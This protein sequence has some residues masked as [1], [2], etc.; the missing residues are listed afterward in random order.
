MVRTPAAPLGKCAT[1]LAAL[2][3]IF[4]LSIPLLRAQDPL[5]EVENNALDQSFRRWWREYERGTLADLD[6]EFTRKRPLLHPALRPP[7][8][9]YA[10]A[11]NRHS[12]SLD[13]VGRLAR[14]ARMDDAEHVVQVLRHDWPKHRKAQ[15]LRALRGA[16]LDSLAHP[17]CPVTVQ[18]AVLD[19]IRDGERRIDGQPLTLEHEQPAFAAR[20][21]PLLAS[22]HPTRFRS[23]L[24]AYCRG[25]QPR[26]AARAAEALAR[27]NPPG[28]LAAI[29][30][31]IQRLP[32]V[33]PEAPDPALLE[34]WRT[35]VQA[36]KPVLAKR[37]VARPGSNALIDTALGRCSS[38]TWLSTTELLVPLILQFRRARSVPVLIDALAR[39]HELSR[40]S[41][42]PTRLPFQIAAVHRALQ[43]LTGFTAPANT[44]DRWREFWT[45]A[46][47][48]FVVP[49]PKPTVSTQTTAGFYGIPV[50]GRRVVFILDR[51][52][53]M[54]NP[55]AVETAG[56]RASPIQVL[57]IDHAKAELLAAVSR[58]PENARF[59][60]LV[61]GD[62]VSSAANMNSGKRALENLRARLVRIRPSGGTHLLAALRHGL[63]GRIQAFSGGAHPSVD[64]VF[65]LSDG[66][67]ASAPDEILRAV[68]RW[69]PG[70][71]ARIHA[72][73]LGGT[74]GA[75]VVDTSGDA[76]PAAFMRRLAEENGGQFRQAR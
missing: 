74:P 41:R 64:E 71:T 47:A 18:G 3:P 35:L 60:V 52:G 56:T 76:S 44:P 63:R 70:A 68:R 16:I 21:L 40:R 29:A 39:G 28:T 20:V 55:I 13:L 69:N 48:G 37:V 66:A 24:L 23:L 19:A 31:A 15:A 1:L 26:V 4:V 59:Q 53:S 43:D 9:A 34:D 65:V 51:S 10:G 75:G 17:D 73:F 14:R 7:R 6:P 61:F 72:V 38:E 33:T 42:Y 30:L 45:G 49:P 32:I 36:A 25:G 62:S 22:F 46:E 54:A 8:S 67:P 12:E 58:L 11:Y 5:S 27:S 57:R 2:I 50:R